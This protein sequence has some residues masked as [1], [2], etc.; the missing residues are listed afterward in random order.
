MNITGVD[1]NAIIGS[2]SEFDSEDIVGAYG[3]GQR[4]A[5]GDMLVAWMHGLHIAAVTTMLHKPYDD[6][7][8]HELWSTHSRRQIDYILLDEIRQTCLQNFG[9]C[10][11][12]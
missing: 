3:L 1:A 12:V 8:S 10:G 9:I 6:C 11:D 4:N 5:R 7:W 2:R